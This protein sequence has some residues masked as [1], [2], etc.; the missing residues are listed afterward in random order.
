GGLVDSYSLVGLAATL[1]EHDPAA[2]RLIEDPVILVE[3]SRIERV[4]VVSRFG[5]GGFTEDETR[6]LY[7]FVKRA[8]SPA[9]GT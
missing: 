7:E 4:F 1:A 9:L 8:L 3:L 2:K 6:R 5:G